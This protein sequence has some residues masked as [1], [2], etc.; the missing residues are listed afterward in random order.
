MPFTSIYPTD[1]R[2]N[3]WNFCYKILKIGSFEKLSFFESA[4]LDYFFQFFFFSVAR[5]GQNFDDYPG[6]QPKTTHPNILG[7][8]VDVQIVYFMDENL[9][10]F[11][12]KYL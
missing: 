5:M 10:R 11:N 8:S 1:P 6:F 7:G 9:A 4:N 3:P 2:T 12:R